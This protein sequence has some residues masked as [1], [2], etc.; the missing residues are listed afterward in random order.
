VFSCGKGWNCP[1]NVQAFVY[2]LLCLL[3]I[4]TAM[5]I[6]VFQL[7]STIKNNIFKF[8]F[9]LETCSRCGFSSINTSTALQVPRRRGVR[10]F[11]SYPVDGDI[12]S[13]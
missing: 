10:P 7:E 12:R 5:I 9:S 8:Y 2:Y 3:R 4:D 1:L 6:D 13:D 11:A